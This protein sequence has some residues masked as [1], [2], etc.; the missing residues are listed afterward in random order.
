M[1]NKKV[2]ILMVLSTFGAVSGVNTFAMNYLRD[3]NHEKVQVDF[4]VFLDR[5][6]SYIK[7]IESYGGKTFLL[8]SIKNIFQHFNFCIKLIKNGGYDIVH[9]NS[10]LLSI[11]LILI[12]KIYNVKV[13]ILH[14][15]A[16]RLGETKFKE[17]RNKIV[18]PLLKRCS[19]EYVACSKAA[20]ESMFNNAYYKVIPNV[21]NINK[22]GFDELSRYQIREKMN[23]K[24]EVVIG[25]VGR[26]AMQKNPFFALDVFKIFLKVVP[27][28]QYWWIGNGPLEKEIN[29]YAHKIGIAKQVRF[30]GKRD[31]VIDLYQALDCFFLP[32]LFEGL[33]LT[34]IEAQAM[35]LPML[36]SSTVTREMVYTDLVAFLS[37]ESSLKEWADML[38]VAVNKSVDRTQYKEQLRNS[39]FSN[40]GCGKRLM[41]IYSQMLNK[42]SD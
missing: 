24:D 15:H 17:I 29:N 8:P 32:S 36:V 42:K 23:V 41:N 22:Y 33:P 26:L 31:D 1:E 19:T 18:L 2:K 7:E 34:G 3:I 27:N 4:V 11:P 20:G 37:L 30:L 28:A 25:T 35:G 21:I 14:S 39:D 9:N 16:T 12:A 5:D 6:S 38:L 10:L 40:V 13:R